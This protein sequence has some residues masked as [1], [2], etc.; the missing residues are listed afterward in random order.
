MISPVA[1]ELLTVNKKAFGRKAFKTPTPIHELTARHILNAF[2]TI[3]EA[4]KDAM[5]EAA[6]LSSVI[7]SYSKGKFFYIPKRASSTKISSPVDSLINELD[8]NKVTEPDFKK[9]QALLNEKIKYLEQNPIK[10]VPF[11][12]ELSPKDKNF[13]SAYLEQMGLDISSVSPASKRRIAASYQRD[14]KK[15]AYAFLKDIKG[16]KRPIKN[17][18]DVFSSY[19]DD[20]SLSNHFV[21]PQQEFEALGD[22]LLPEIKKKGQVIIDKVLDLK[23]VDV[24]DKDT[25]RL[26]LRNRTDINQD[27]KFSDVV[28]KKFAD[29]NYSIEPLGYSFILYAYINELN[30]EVDKKTKRG[31]AMVNIAAGE[32]IEA[33][34]KG[35]LKDALRFIPTDWIEQSNN[36]G[37]IYAAKSKDE[38]SDGKDRAFMGFARVG[39]A[40]SSNQ[41][42]LLGG[43]GLLGTPQPSNSDYSE[44]LHHELAHRFQAVLPEIDA[45][46]QAEHRRR[47]KDLAK[48]QIR[49]GGETELGIEDDYPT[50]YYGRM[51]EDKGHSGA[52]EVMPMALTVL[53]KGLLNKTAKKVYIGGQAVAFLVDDLLAVSLGVLTEFKAV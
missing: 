3:P 18:D 22:K 28:N 50:H 9:A 49:G 36:T 51:Y 5:V 25:Y 31:G 8:D 2:D 14:S 12:K 1:P 39:G 16:V 47:T 24:L 37:A 30:K 26:V 46:F 42:N 23:L 29:E 44:T 7:D 35:G 21:F 13:N 19:F 4:T 41:Y 43:D 15:A 38:N 27:T 11:T 48:T 33:K 10:P 53:T 34:L 45:V 6:L 17:I 40:Y 20:V 52:L 32:D